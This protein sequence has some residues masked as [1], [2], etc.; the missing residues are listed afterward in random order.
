MKKTNTLLGIIIVLLIGISLFI[1][2]MY[3]QMTKDTQ[4]LNERISDY[5]HQF[6]VVTKHVD[7]VQWFNLLGDVAYIDKARIAGPPRHKPLLRNNA[8]KDSL[9]TNDMVFYTYVFI[10]RNI[11]PQSKV[12][13]VVFSHGGVHASLS[14]VSAHTIREL[15]AQGY[16]VVAP[17]YRGSTG[18]GKG[19]WRNID[20][21]GLENED[22][23]AS[24]DYVVESYSFI[25]P[26]RVGLVGWSHGG[27]IS[28]MNLLNYPDKYA[29]AYAGVPVSDVA[30]R[31]SYQ[32]KD[33]AKLFSAD[34][35]IGETVEQNEQ[36]YLR[37]S[38]VGHAAK[39]VKPLMITTAEND[40]DVSVKEVQRMIDA[41]TEHKKDFEYKVYGPMSGAHVFDRLDTK[42]ATDIRYL[43]Y[44]FIEPYLNP[45]HPFKDE[46]EM[47]KASYGFD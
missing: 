26:D 8:F 21:G 35:H 43:A 30:F 47:R 3:Q 14:L 2:F 31:L 16:V 5:T 25:D 6:D 44:K 32:T 24:R 28:L 41:L 10:P 45:P 13:L 17:D 9:A 27:M 34:Y 33:Y 1:G 22:V 42:E 7:D 4:T 46:S 19:F 38:P 40:D 12:P 20:Y 18:Y 36:E 15:I 11:D 39:L 37:R 29:C 23:L